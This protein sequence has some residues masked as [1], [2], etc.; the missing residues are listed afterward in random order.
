MSKNMLVLRH[1][2]HESLGTL[3]DSFET[4]GLQYQYRDLFTQHESRFEPGEW[5][6]LVVLGGPM[7][8]DETD[9][10]PFLATEIDWIRQALAAGLPILGVCLGAQLLSK[11]LGSRVYANRVK[12]IGWYPLWITDEG[13]R[14]RLF[15]GSS[16][17]ET[18]FQ[19]HGDTFDLPAGAVLL[20]TTPEC[21]HQAFRYGET[22]YGLQF[23]LEM[24][25][26]M[27]DDWLAAPESCAE[28]G[29]LDYIH[30][31]AI[32]AQTPVQIQA[33]S[34]LAERVFARFA[35]LCKTHAS[36]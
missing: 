23:H 34:A 2:P 9:R 17:I 8:V 20:A 36:S 30:P 5:A 3:A 6:A 24:T 19:W 11:A 27:V 29:Q 14:D 13:R 26:E 28:L 12:E 10:Y 32:L 18:A 1:V 7:N 15:A 21:R 25:G 16:G 22:A 31:Q 33:M 4:F 35:E